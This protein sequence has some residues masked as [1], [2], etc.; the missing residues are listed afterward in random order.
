MERYHR[1]MERYHRLMERYHRLMERYHRLMKRYHRLMERYHR[2]VERYHRLVKR[3]HRLMKKSAGNRAAG[4]MDPEYSL[5]PLPATGKI[6]RT[7]PMSHPAF[8]PIQMQAIAYEVAV[9]RS[10][11]RLQNIGAALGILFIAALGGLAA[12][13]LCD[14]AHAAENVAVVPGMLLMVLLIPLVVV[15]SWKMV[16]CLIPLIFYLWARLVDMRRRVM[17]SLIQ[18]A[19]ETG[20]PPAE[21]IRA[22]AAS[23]SRFFRK[24]LDRLADSLE[25]GLSPA[26][27]LGQNPGLARYDVCG[28]LALGADEKQTLQTLEDIS[29][30][31]RN[32]ALSESNS[33]FRVGY[34]LALC[35]PIFPV[36]IFLMMW[37]VPQYIKIFE[38]FGISLPP[39]TMAIVRFTEF[40]IDFWFLFAPIV[41]V[42]IAALVFY[43]IMQTDVVT[44][45][46]FGLRRLF[47]S[48]DAARFLRI[49]CTGL[50]NQ[51]PIPDSI[52]TYQRVAGS[53]YL[54]DTA[55]RINTKIQ[56]GG[57]WIDAFR[58][59]GMVTS[60][61]SRLLETAERTGNLP[62]VIDQIATS[63]ELKHSGTSDLVSKF[64]FIPCIL[65]IGTLVGLIVIGMFMPIVELTRALS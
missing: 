23:C 40:F 2:L 20:T 53:S 56:N 5:K 49:F 55:K 25:R 51:V 30:D 4:A 10:R 3:Y 32:R 45:R 64:V 16:V 13:V 11:Q 50:K 26:A 41:P 14:P 18:T 43:L 9:R 63:K 47:R 31:S 57:N 1:L 15:F 44:A 36:T 48:L 65:F 33:V 12:I 7:H 37:I 60:R 8:S 38:D 17:L 46:P 39:L 61:E 35:L 59:A 29:H 27:A 62:V 24:S 6:I 28:I 42:V 19:M 22:Y 58:G 54:K 34:L 52:D 21:M